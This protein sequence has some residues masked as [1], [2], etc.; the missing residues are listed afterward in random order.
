MKSRSNAKASVELESP[1]EPGELRSKTLFYLS[2]ILILPFLSHF[3]TDYVLDAARLFGAPAFATFFGA[4]RWIGT[5]ITYAAFLGFTLF[6]L[7]V[8]LVPLATYGLRWS[9][10]YMGLAAAIG[11]VSGLVM[12]AIDVALPASFTVPPATVFG[13]V[14]GIVTVALLPALFEELLFRGVIQRFYSRFTTRSLS[15]MHWQ[16]PFA[17]FI[18][19]GFELLFHLAFPAYFNFFGGEL[20]GALVGTI[21]QLCYVALFGAIGGYLYHRTGSLVVPLL[22]HFLGNAI[23]LIALWLFAHA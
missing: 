20:S 17:V 2:I 23:E 4:N 7:R 13:I 10:E 11:F 3:L 12:Y 9:R 8:T 5:G 22:I 15:V 21:P 1:L 18:A 14:G 16:V 19:S 6:Y